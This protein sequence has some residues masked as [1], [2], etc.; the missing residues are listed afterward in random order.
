MKKVAN[1][2]ISPLVFNADDYLTT[3]MPKGEILELKDAFDL[4]DTT[5]KGTIDPNGKYLFI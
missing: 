1:Q 3:G 5:N 2:K 4:L